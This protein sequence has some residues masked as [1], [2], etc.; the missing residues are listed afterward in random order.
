[1]IDLVLEASA[2]KLGTVGLVL[3]SVFVQSLDADSRW[4]HYIAVDVRNGQAAFLGFVGLGRSR[5]HLRIDQRELLSFD[6]H[7]RQA[8]GPSDLRSSETNALSSVHR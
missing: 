8:L 5:D 2:Q 6:V 3:V 4:T 1:M 7:D